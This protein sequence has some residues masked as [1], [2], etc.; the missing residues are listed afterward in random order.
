MNVYQST[1]NVLWYAMRAMCPD[2]ADLLCLRYLGIIMYVKD[3]L[4]ELEQD[5][6]ISK[7]AMK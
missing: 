2:T 3:I 5:V 7:N 4:K 1:G 6:K